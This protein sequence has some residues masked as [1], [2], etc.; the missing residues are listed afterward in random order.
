MEEI[1]VYDTEQ[2]AEMFRTHRNNVCMWREIGI[3]QAI[4][5]GKGYMFPYEEIKRFEREYVGLDI[6]NRVK[7]IESYKMVNNT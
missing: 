3:I 1:K 5:T 7:A 6:S 4:K 2:V